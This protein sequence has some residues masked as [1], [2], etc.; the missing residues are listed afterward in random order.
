VVTYAIR[1]PALAAL[2]VI[3]WSS[4]DAHSVPVLFEP[5]HD[6]VLRT[7][8]GEVRILFN[9][10]I[11]PAFSTIAVTDS[12]GRRVDKGD[13]RVDRRNPRLLRVRL[14]GLLPGVYSVRW[15]ILAIDG[16]Q[17]DGTYVFTLR[18]AG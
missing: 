5:R 13:T 7:A 16:H 3:A 12:A 11:E 6:A 17:S 4:V 9:G 2:S 18:S 15:R 1:I 10:E 14:G 8:P